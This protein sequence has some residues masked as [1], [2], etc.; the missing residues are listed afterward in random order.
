MSVE[1]SELRQANLSRGVR[2][3][4]GMSLYYRARYYDA[5]IG[6]FISEDPS[7][8]N[9]AQD[10]FYAYV[11]NSPAHNV[12]PFGLALCYFNL[13]GP[14]GMGLMICLPEKP[15][16]KPLTFPANSGNNGDPDHKCQNNSNCA[17]D[18]HGPLPLGTYRFGGPSISH[19]SL[20][21]IH[22]NPTGSD[23]QYGA[24][25]RFL[26]HWCMRGWNNQQTPFKSGHFCSEGCIV[27]SPENVQAL[28]DLLAKEPGSKLFV[29][30]W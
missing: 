25:G 19:S 13:N 2:S 26:T 28:N 10:N 7:R 22:L 23:N 27:S 18:A 20:G 15:G 24:D 4:V 30:S 9:S 8:F 12:D 21:G 17:P 3:G 14:N 16:D 29:S 1:Q 11:G 5:P 6:R